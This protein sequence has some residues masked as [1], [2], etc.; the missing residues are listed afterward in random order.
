MPSR[1]YEIVRPGSIF[2]ESRSHSMRVPTIELD[3]Q[4]LVGVS[5]I[6]AVTTTADPDSILLN[7]LREP[8]RE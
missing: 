2:I 4:L 6:D 3:G 8:G 1:N 5:Q 7:E